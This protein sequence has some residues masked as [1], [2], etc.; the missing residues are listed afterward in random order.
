MAI[1]DLLE[2]LKVLKISLI[3]NPVKRDFIMTQNGLTEED[4][5]AVMK[6]DRPTLHQTI[7]IAHYNLAVEHEFIK[8]YMTA[9]LNYQK[10]K[11]FA[12]L[13]FKNTKNQTD[14]ISQIDKCI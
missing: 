14:F 8:E 12:C 6:E 4:L 11:F 2:T 7:G 1:E 5:A 9:L 10:S 3:K 13:R